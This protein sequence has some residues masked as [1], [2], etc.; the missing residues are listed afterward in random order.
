MDYKQLVQKTYSKTY[1][2]VV[3]LVNMLKL[4]G[5]LSEDELKKFY[6][7]EVSSLKPAIKVIKKLGFKQLGSTHLGGFSSPTLRLSITEL[8]SDG[9]M[10]S[11]SAVLPNAV[12]KRATK[13]SKKLRD[14]LGEIK[15]RRKTLK[16]LNLETAK[17]NG[18]TLIAFNDNLFVLMDDGHI[19]FLDPAI[20]AVTTFSQ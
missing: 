10:I 18:S 12:L 7:I 9:A 1:N 17:G 14:L 2:E 5:I 15:N 8:S 13:D 20:L 4:V 19:T 3:K 6:E 16:E 11:V